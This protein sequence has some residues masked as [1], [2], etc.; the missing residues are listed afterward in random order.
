MLESATDPGLRATAAR[1]LIEYAE[2]R[3]DTELIRYAQVR[4]LYE[5]GGVWEPEIASAAR[6]TGTAPAAAPAPA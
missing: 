5:S 1:L 6:L 2:A 4:T 3:G